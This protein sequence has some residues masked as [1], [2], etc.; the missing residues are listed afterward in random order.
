MYK[1]PCVDHLELLGVI[2]DNSPLFDEHVTKIIK[3]VG[4][5]LDVLCRFKKILSSSTELCL[6]SLFIMSYF[7]V[8]LHHPIV[9]NLTVKSLIN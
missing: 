4:K 5:H 9:L 8:L 1:I 3:K 2:I 6:Y 7:Y